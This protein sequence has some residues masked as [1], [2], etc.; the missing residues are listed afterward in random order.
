MADHDE[1][2]TD[3]L[4]DLVNALQVAAP[5]AAHQRSVLGDLAQDAITLDAAVDRA[6]RAVRRLQPDDREPGGAR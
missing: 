1:P 4:S 2:F 3:A 6:A 5:L